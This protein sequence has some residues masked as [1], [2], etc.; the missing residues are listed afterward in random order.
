MNRRG[1]LAAGVSGAGIAIG[2]NAW[3]RPGIDRPRWVEGIPLPYARSEM[4]AAVID[5]KIYVAGGW[6]YGNRVDCFDPVKRE[7][8]LVPPLPFALHHAGVAALGNQLIVAGGYTH[9]EL[10]ALGHVWAWSPGERD[11]AGLASLP[12]PRGAFGMTVLAGTLYA[13]GGAFEQLGGPV[14]GETLRYDPARDRW[15]ELAAMPTPREHLAV[16]AAGGRVYAIGGRADGD[17]GDRYAAANEAYDPATDAWSVVSPLPAPRGGL[18]GSLTGD[19][20][21]VLG[22]ERDSK[23]YADAN[24]YDPAGDHWDALPALPTAR[25]GLASAFVAELL[26]AIAGSV[27]AGGVVPIPAVEALWLGAAHA[28]PVP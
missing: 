3:R 13:A 9:D 15:E 5:G 1:L 28:T 21:V 8:S 6:D 14:C 4:A 22:G 2:L 10:I 25:H 19:R 27:L 26:Y 16:V 23:T 11:W 18:S 7:W 24:R 12:S 17:E 20:I